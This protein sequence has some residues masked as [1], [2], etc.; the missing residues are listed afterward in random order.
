MYIILYTAEETRELRVSNIIVLRAV[1]P[2]ME[3][4]FNIKF[5]LLIYTSIYRVTRNEN[6]KN[7]CSTD[8]CVINLVKKR[9]TYSIS[10]RIIIISSYISSITVVRGILIENFTLYTFVRLQRKR[11]L[12]S[13][14]SSWTFF[15]EIKKKR[16][17]HRGPP[18]ETSPPVWELAV[19]FKKCVWKWPS[20]HCGIG[21]RL[22][23]EC[24][25]SRTWKISREILVVFSV[26]EKKLQM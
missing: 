19:F 22:T 20:V 5:L 18:W 24:L 8:G 16:L 2:S 4:N 10:V 25:A 15:F 13:L 26:L 21:K 14:I 1:I 6:I 23:F 17:W 12:Y 9:F 7:L 3:P 11:C